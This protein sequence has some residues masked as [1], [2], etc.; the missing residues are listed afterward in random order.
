MPPQTEKSTGRTKNKL[1]SLWPKMARLD[2]LV[3][4]RDPLEKVYVD[5][6]FAFFLRKWCT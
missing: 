4:P 2:P 1:N 5:P 6:S 3:D